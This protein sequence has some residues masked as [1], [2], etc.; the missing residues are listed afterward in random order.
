MESL[1]NNLEGGVL[2]N[3]NV[4]FSL[5]LKA[6]TKNLE[7]S[8]AATALMQSGFVKSK[9]AKLLGISRVKLD[10]ICKEHGISKVV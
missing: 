9:A 6:A 2:A 1:T 7:G 4:E 10:K 5:N 8:L 3:D